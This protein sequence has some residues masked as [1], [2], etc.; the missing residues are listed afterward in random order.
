M[1]PACPT[2]S[3]PPHCSLYPT[4]GKYGS[5]T[6]P[7]IAHSSSETEIPGLQPLWW[8]G[9]VQSRNV[10]KWL[11]PSSQGWSG[12]RGWEEYRRGGARRRN[13]P[14]YKHLRSGIYNKACP[15]T[16]SPLDWTQREN[17]ELKRVLKNL[18]CVLRCFL[19]VR[20]LQNIR[21]KG[22]S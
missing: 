2:S 17:C 4:H 8:I 22:K 20:K 9:S 16:K 13:I 10:Q 3:F 6:T 19:I 1:F 7:R 5:G 12:R 18:L 15:L 11:S 14:P 21:E